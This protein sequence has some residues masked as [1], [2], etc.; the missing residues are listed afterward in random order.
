[1]EQTKFIFKKYSFASLRKAE[2][3]LRHKQALAAIFFTTLLFTFSILYSSCGANIFSV[4]E[5]VQIGKD[6]DNQI[7]AQP[8]EFPM[9]QG[10]PEVTN[11]VSGIGSYILQT[12]RVK[13][14]NV[15]PYNFQVINDTIVNAF[16]TPGGY[17]YIYTGLISFLD[18]EASL[19]GVI[20]HE[21]AHADQR[22]M[23]QRL[24]SYYGVSTVLG[25]VLG[26]NPNMLAEI[27]ANLFVGLGFLANSRS[28][29]LEADNFSMTYLAGS[30][31]Y[32]GSI[33]FFFDKIREEQRRRGQT[34]GG[35]ERLLSTHPLPQDRID[36][37]KKRMNTITPRPDPTKGL[38]TEE[39]QQ[40][41]AR[42][43]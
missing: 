37:V 21:I 29:E 5:D 43:Q 12:A 20:A 36:N 1:M 19:A 27:A 10:N 32:P 13:H 18:N 25:L 8:R 30:K 33:V 26:G 14:K 7:K 6:V 11:Y 9:L 16:A 35:L 23:T 2:S 28:D 22:H 38:F 3:L 40:L 31:Y 34:P 39:Y 17:I 41:K 42:I 24:T 15:F 4:Q